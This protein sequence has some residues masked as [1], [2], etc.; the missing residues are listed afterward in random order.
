MRHV[1]PLAVFAL[2]CSAE[3][4]PLPPDT[5]APPRDAADAPDTAA[6]DVASPPDAAAPL[7]V[8]EPCDGACPGGL[9]C[10]T[11][12]P[13]GYCTRTCRTGADDCPAG[14][15]CA[16]WTSAGAMCHRVCAAR[17]ECRTEDGY[18][19]VRA[20]GLSAR[21]CAESLASPVGTRR[22]GSACF[23]AAGGAHPLPPL[24]R[25]TFAGPNVPVSA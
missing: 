7:S 11:A 15:A 8:G 19:C 25:R 9:R 2:A 16:A 6:A 5:G 13:G 14:A 4:P 1:W 22:D 24:A 23:T 10:E 18:D 20:P 3:R 12:M 21:I 17:A